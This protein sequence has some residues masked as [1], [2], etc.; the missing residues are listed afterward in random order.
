VEG[1]GCRPLL[2][3]NCADAYFDPGTAPGYSGETGRHVAAMGIRGVHVRSVVRIRRSALR[4]QGADRRTAQKRDTSVCVA[5]VAVYRK[6]FWDRHPEWR[7]KNS[8]LQDA[9]LDFLYLMDLQNP[10]C[11]NTALKELDD[12]LDEDWTA[13]TSLNSRSR[14][15]GR[16][17]LEGPAMPEFFTGFNR[18]RQKRVLAPKG[19]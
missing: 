17:A 13:L 9:H 16:E 18:L 5:R 4:L 15:P 10:E 2:T 11:M 6:G 19:I 12:L 1:L 3:R 7:Q 14:A 8:L